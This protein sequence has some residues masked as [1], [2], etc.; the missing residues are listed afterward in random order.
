MTNIS[1]TIDA[2]DAANRLWDVAV[3]GAGP[4][5]SMA[6]R[7]LAIRG[8]HV[9]LIDKAAFPR[10]K[11]C[12]CC[13]NASSQARLRAAGLPDLVRQLGAEQIHRFQLACG[14]RTANLPINGTVSLSRNAF[15]AALVAAA[16]EAGAAFLP[17]CEAKLDEASE[18]FRGLSLRCKNQ[19]HTIRAKILLAADGLNSGLMRGSR[20]I[21]FVVRQNSR[22]GV[23]IIVE[24]DLTEFENG[25]IYM[26]CGSHG[27]VG[28]VR[29]ENYML[30]IAAALDRTALKSAGGIGPLVVQ[31]LRQANY[32][33]VPL[34]DQM[35]WQGTPLL[36]QRPKCIGTHRAFLI[37]DAAGYVEPFTGEGIAWALAGGLAVAPIADRASDAWD[38]AFE[39][40][41]TETYNQ[42]VR[43]RQRFCR[44]L[45]KGLRF[46]R[47]TRPAI[48]LLS[49]FPS[50]ARPISRALT[51]PK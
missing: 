43:R 3:V 7:Q 14:H 9:L 15:D 51:A 41:W 45:S 32:P 42:L 34:L 33:V 21:D 27:Y 5:G 31:I 2:N 24:S 44:L 11:V 30:D 36:S 26:A 39:Q 20:D 47:I 22:L 50:I 16:I 25:T 46:P 35:K 4:A 12:G 29:L 10:S 8:R 28:L 1:S 49:R 18:Q 37:G 19:Q 38:P 23:G 40:E 17:Q 48:S 13:L 6:A